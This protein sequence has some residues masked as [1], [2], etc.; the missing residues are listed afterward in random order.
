MPRF[1]EV[2]NDPE[3]LNAMKV[4]HR[5]PLQMKETALP[6]SGKSHN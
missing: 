2:L 3:V 4:T 5:N 6:P 1:H